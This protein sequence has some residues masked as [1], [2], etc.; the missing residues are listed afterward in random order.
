MSNAIVSIASAPPIIIEKLN[1]RG[2][3]LHVMM[4]AVLALAKRPDHVLIDGNVIPNDMPMPASA[5][6]KGDT[7][8]LS[9]AAASIVAKVVRDRMCHNMDID[10]PQYNFAKHKAYGTKIHLEALNSFGVTKHHRISFAPVAKL[11]G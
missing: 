3:S 11:L 9:I 7:K 4:Q 2:A 6:I 8:S 5:I 1:I 10:Y